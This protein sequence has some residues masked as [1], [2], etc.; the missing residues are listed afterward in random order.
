[1][2]NI[3]ND[4]RFKQNGLQGLRD[5]VPIIIAYFPLAM[6]FGVLAA[7]S[8]LPSFLAILSSIWVYSGGGQFMIVSMVSALVAPITMIVM[9]LLVN[10]RHVLYGT[11][12]G[13]YMKQWGLQS[14]LIAALGLTDEV[15]ALIAS[16]A[17]QE[18]QLSEAYYISFAI[19]C[20]ISWIA[21]TVAGV[22]IGSFVPNELSDILSFTLP[23]LFLALLFS[24]EKTIAYLLSAGV[25]AVVA[26]IMNMVGLGSVGLILGGLI[27]AT[28][29]YVYHQKQQV[30][31]HPK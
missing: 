19:P 8:G 28:S 7:A 11:T 17:R 4:L 18:Q 14:K 22:I 16:K 25:G 12:L 24:G 21:G 1:M 13:P 29:G 15:F 27:G 6:T 30:L 26:I 2:V 9:I 23:A 10:M 3:V 31:M 5:A 20:Y